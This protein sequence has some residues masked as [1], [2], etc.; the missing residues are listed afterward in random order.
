MVD[1]RTFTGLEKVC[2]AYVF[3]DKKDTK[4]Y[5]EYWNQRRELKTLSRVHY[6]LVFALTRSLSAYKD[7]TVNYEMPTT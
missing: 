7:N 4:N 2:V 6:A 5:M 3:F 1:A